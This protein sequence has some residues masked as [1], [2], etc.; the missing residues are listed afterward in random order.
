MPRLTIHQKYAKAR[1]QADHLKKENNKLRALLATRSDEFPP[2][3]APT[4][5]ERMQ[6][7]LD[8]LDQDEAPDENANPL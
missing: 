6:A 4:D 8:K 5:E 2:Y 3:K 7:L 1:N